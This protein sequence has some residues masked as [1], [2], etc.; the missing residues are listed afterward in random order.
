LEIIFSKSLDNKN[1]FFK[2]NDFVMLAKEAVDTFVREG[3]IIEAPDNISKDFLKKK[4]G[5]F[6]TI[7]KNGILRGC[8]GTVA[9]GY[10]N[11]A[12]EIIANAIAAAKDDFRFGR[13]KAEELD[14]LSYE[15]SVL[16]KPQKVEDPSKLNPK[17]HGVIVVC[18]DGRSGLLLPDIEGVESSAAQILIACQKGGID[19][20]NDDFEIFCFE[21]EKYKMAD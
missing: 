6:V 1:N 16:K 9:P 8:V 10:K 2:M 17:T 14:S 18:P 7:K 5:V 20:Q 21:A 3:R 13:I 12:E 4:A 11:I 15:V 19:P